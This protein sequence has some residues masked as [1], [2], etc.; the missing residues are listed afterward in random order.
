[1]LKYDISF[2]YKVITTLLNNYNKLYKIGDDDPS[3]DVWNIAEKGFGINIRYISQWPY[4]RKHAVIEVKKGLVYIKLNEKDRDNIARCRFSI[5]H[6][7]GHLVFSHIAIPINVA[8]RMFKYNISNEWIHFFNSVPISI[9]KFSQ[10]PVP[11]RKLKDMYELLIKETGENIQIPDVELTHLFRPA[12]IEKSRKKIKPN[13][14]I[15]IL[16]N[17]SIAHEWG[18]IEYFNN[19]CKVSLKPSYEAASRYITSKN[20]FSMLFRFMFI[21]K[22][23]R[24]ELADRFAANLLVPIYRFQYY[25]DKSDNELAKLFIV[26]E[27]CIKKR[28]KE[29]KTEMNALTAAV[30]P[31]SIEEVVDPDVEINIDDYLEYK[32]SQ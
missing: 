12:A 16:M 20:P 24:E 3:V 30:K 19:Y 13:K 6:E 22:W 23:G 28:R 7:L 25:L 5:A 11:D 32:A 18:R 31:L 27:K 29:L 21:K 17:Y 8:C 14:K 26:D 10:L 1:M 9:P 4:G 15:K 2:I